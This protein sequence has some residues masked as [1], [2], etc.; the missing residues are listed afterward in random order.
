MSL[1]VV[2]GIA[3]G[4]DLRLLESSN[5]KDSINPAIKTRKIGLINFAKSAYCVFIL[6]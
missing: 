4:L 1:E 2:F 6:S 5:V 3:L